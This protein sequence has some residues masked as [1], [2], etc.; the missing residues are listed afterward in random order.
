MRGSTVTWVVRWRESGRDSRQLARVF[1]TRA[2]A[3]AFEAEIK[4]RHRLG[5]HAPALP[6]RDRLSDWLETWFMDGQLRWARSTSIP[7]LSLLQRWIV[8]YLG[9]TR[10]SDLG[11]RRVLEWRREI[12][13]AGCTS[14]QANKALSTL[15]AALSAAVEEELLPANPCRGVRR[16]PTARFDARAMSPDEAERLRACMPTQRDRVLLGLLTYAG[17]RPEEA[18]PLRW[19]DVDDHR[20]MVDRTWTAGEIRSRTKTGP[21]R[22]VELIAP[23]RDDLEQLRRE[24][25]PQ[26][27]D[28]L[29][30]PTEAGT[31]LDLNNWRPRVWDPAAAQAG[32]EWTT[33]YTGRRTYISLR[34]HAGDSPLVVA[35]AVG[36]AN[37]ETL[38]R[39]YAR[40][41]ERAR[42]TPP[43]P[44]A[45]AV[46]SARARTLGRNGVRPVC[47]HTNVIELAAFRR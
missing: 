26:S 15:S 9:D 5:A 44:I 32:L 45:D 24:S 31:P 16:L 35:A 41:F 17:L 8:P 25:L 20:I 46:Q 23:L 29:I 22:D 4:S 21:G 1:T 39:H 13:Q 2:S 11:R 37:G 47:A 36:H 10:L 38:W 28:D 34:I 7:R 40:E 6:S 27:M 14:T 42:T 43:S 18:L 19:R 12:T 30:C 3:D 33:P